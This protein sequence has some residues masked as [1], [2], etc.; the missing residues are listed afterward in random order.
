MAERT[1]RLFFALWPDAATRALVVERTAPHLRAAGGRRVPPANLHVTIA[2]LGGVAE[3]SLTRLQAAADALRA[4]AFELCLARVEHWRGSRVLC[5]EIPQPPPALL[6]LVAAVGQVQR[7]CGMPPDARPFHAHLTLARAAHAPQGLA[8]DIEPIA[9]AVK[10]LC[11]MESVTAAE[12]ARYEQLRS[13][14]LA[15][16]YPVQ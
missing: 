6:E 8:P 7:A 15:H 5:L 3:S 12:G 4:A 16:R 9:W 10:T 2:F 11:L 1:R 13:W 14:P